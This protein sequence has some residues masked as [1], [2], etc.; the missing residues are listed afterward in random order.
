MLGITAQDKAIWNLFS[1]VEKFQVREL[2]FIK[3][4][5]QIIF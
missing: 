4:N 5:L 2:D 1:A 3:L